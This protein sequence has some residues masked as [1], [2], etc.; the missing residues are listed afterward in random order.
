MVNPTSS[1]SLAHFN[2][3][4]EED[5]TASQHNQSAERKPFHGRVFNIIC[6]MGFCIC[7][8]ILPY[9]TPIDRTDEATVMTIMDEANKIFDPVYLHRYHHG[10]EHRWFYRL[11]ISSSNDYIDR[12]EYRVEIDP[13]K[14]SKRLT[15]TA[16]AAFQQQESQ[17]R[18]SVFDTQ[19]LSQLDEIGADIQKYYRAENK[20][21]QVG[22]FYS[23]GER[24]RME[25]RHEVGFFEFETSTGM[26][27][28]YY[29]A[30]FDGHKGSQCASFAA[31]NIKNALAKRLGEFNKIKCTELG[32]WNAL[33]LAMVDIDRTYVTNHL[34]VGGTTA[35]II[36]VIDDDLWVINVGDSRAV[37]VSSEGDA[38]QLSED[39][40][41]EIPK[42]KRGIEKRGGSV[43]FSYNCYRVNGYLGVARALGDYDTVSAAVSARPKI[44]K[45]PKP[46]NGWEGLYVIQ[47]C[48]GLFDVCSSEQVA[49]MFYA[50]QEKKVSINKTAGYLVDGA[51]KAQ[52]ADNIT[53]IISDLHKLNR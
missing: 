52:S 12:L 1:T 25:D 2:S 42:Y 4:Q 27:E 46:A 17:Q 30:L 26:K 18:N 37:L 34:G 16:I 36:L 24:L 53:V 48:D 47:G 33:K 45:Y 43:S 7:D 40:K 32:V 6:K 39:A 51:L 41:P 20:T 28:V 9:S 50:C 15:D 5:P 10:S 13:L 49:E 23:Q 44:V 35:N 14:V 3:L 21:S 31:K 29:A 22:I 11:A 19:A 38:I 8:N